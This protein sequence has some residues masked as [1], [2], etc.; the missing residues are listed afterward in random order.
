M[1]RISIA[2]LSASLLASSAF[3]N[4]D[5]VVATYKGGEVKESQIMQQFQSSLDNQPS[6]KGKKFSDLNANIQ[7]M[8][9]HGYIDTKLLEQEAKNSNIESSKEFQ[10]KLNI[11]K[12]Q[13]IQQELME[14]YVKS[15]VDEKM[16]NAEYD[17]LVASLEGKEEVKVSHIL[18]AT[19]KE[20][21]NIKNRLNKGEKF[22]KL[23]KDLSKDEGS[24]ENGGEIGYITSGQLVPEFENK[25]LSMKVNEISSPVKTQFGWHIIM[26]LDKR[27]VQ[28]PSKE[29]A[30]ANITNRL[31]RDAI[32]K[33]VADLESKADVKI[34]LPQSQ[35][36]DE[37]KK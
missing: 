19:E 20:A 15:H 1:K 27:P 14:R 13:M 30:T 24:K 5:K 22:A 12:N 25:A 26:V 18:L 3:A 28:I 17:K 6:A 33:Y 9:V 35:V 8:L 29:E 36:T 7:K 32:L 4:E 34:M 31:S 2:F 10:A 16:I 11:A 37:T 23:A 21:V